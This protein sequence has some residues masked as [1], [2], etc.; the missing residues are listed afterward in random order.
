M[1]NRDF[2]FFDPELD[3]A[4]VAELL[5]IVAPDRA[6]FV[7]LC[8]CDIAAGYAAEVN[9]AADRLFGPMA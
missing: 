5:E 9:A 6:T 2:P 7:W 4:Y 8:Q 1:K 3:E